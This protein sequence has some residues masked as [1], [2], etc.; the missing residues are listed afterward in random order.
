MSEL[1]LGIDLGGTKVE[2]VLVEAD[3]PDR[4]VHRLRKPT[5]A[6]NGYEHIVGVIASVCEE[7]CQEAGV[8]LPPAIGMGTPGTVDPHSGSLRGSNT[9]CLNG[10]HLAADLGAHLPARWVLSNDAN[11]FALAEATLGS[12]RNYEVVF[13]IIFGTGVGGGLVVRGEVVG[14]HHGVAGEWGQLVLDPAG[15]LSPH[16]TRGTIEA[17]LAGP[18]LEKFYR[19]QGGAPLRLPVIIERARSGQ[20]AAAQATLD[21]LLQLTPQALAMLVCVLDPDCFI[22]GGGVGRIEELYSPLVR[23]RLA[24]LSF[25]GQF[26]GTILAPSLGDSAGVFGAALLTRSSHQSIS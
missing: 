18:A 4:P 23:E 6:E 9:Q 19:E 1:L 14:G 3:H 26:S 13:C 22:L 10:R 7:L 21:R 5:G 24:R 16:G 12:G 17:H 8:P 11:C 25:A 15:P 2:G 20:D